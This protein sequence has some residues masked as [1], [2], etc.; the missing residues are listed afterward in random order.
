MTVELQQY[1]LNLK[2][3]N[4]SCILGLRDVILGNHLDIKECRKYGMPC[5]TL[6]KSILCYLWVNKKSLSPYILFAFGYQINH[7]AL[8]Q[9]DRKKMKVLKVNPEEDLDIV[10]IKEVMDISISLMK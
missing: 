2:E 4:K 9:G 8:E 10:T 1:Y 7:P 6:N 5:F 3:P